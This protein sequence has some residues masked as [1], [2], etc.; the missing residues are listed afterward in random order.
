MNLLR[1]ATTEIRRAGNFDSVA[2]V[3]PTGIPVER[4]TARFLLRSGVSEAVRIRAI[5]PE[6]EWGVIGLSSEART[7]PSVRRTES[8]RGHVP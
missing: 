4:L 6:R 1:L 3:R 8:P 5:R 2:V 7:V